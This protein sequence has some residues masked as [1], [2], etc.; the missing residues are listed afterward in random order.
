M[1]YEHVVLTRRFDRVVDARLHALSANTLLMKGREAYCA[2]AEIC[3]S[4]GPGDVT[5]LE[6]QRREIFARMIF[7]MLIDNTDDHAKNHAFLRR[8]EGGLELSKAYDIPPQMN[9]MG[10]Q[11]L[12][13]APDQPDFT[14]AAAIASSKRFGL[15]EREAR[16]IWDSVAR[17]VDRWKDAFTE[18]GVTPADIDYLAD[19][20]DAEAKLDLRCVP[21]SR[22]FDG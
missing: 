14:R 16:E 15:S 9:G 4:H 3:R 22:D 8:P 11:A 17:G 12:P 5:F 21:V 10:E 20:L 1:G 6:S 18:L 19:F 2:L 7:N 13:I